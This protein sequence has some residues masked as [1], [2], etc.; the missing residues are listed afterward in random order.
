MSEPRIHKK[1]EAVYIYILGRC[2]HGKQS[3]PSL[4]VSAVLQIFI[5][6]IL[7]LSFIPGHVGP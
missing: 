7:E 1:P 6:P 2:Y 5:L 3:K 4:M